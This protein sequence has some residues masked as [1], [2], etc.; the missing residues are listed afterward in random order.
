MKKALALVLVV[1][2]LS[3]GGMC[4]AVSMLSKQQVQV[5]VTPILEQG[6]PAVLEGLEVVLDSRSGD[7]QMHW[8]TTYRP[9]QTPDADTQPY[10]KRFWNDDSMI[11][12][13]Y[14]Y[15]HKDEQKRR[16]ELIYYQEDTGYGHVDP[17]DYTGLDLA[18]QQLEQS[19]ELGTQSARTIAVRD[20]RPFYD[21][22]ARF[23]LP[24]V[25]GYVGAYVRGENWTDLM[26]AQDYQ[27]E[28]LNQFLRIPVQENEKVTITLTKDSQGEVS[29]FGMEQQNED[30]FQFG[31]SSDHSLATDE[32]FY[33]TFNNRTEQ[34][35]VV[36][37]SLI[38][39]GYGIYRIP[40]TVDFDPNKETGILIDQISTVYSIDPSHE[41]LRLHSSHDKSKLLL[42]TLE[43]GWYVLT[44]IDRES[45]T[46]LQR[47]E[48]QE[49]A[50]E[51]DFWKLWEDEEQDIFMV[52]MDKSYAF[53]ALQ[54]DGTYAQIFLCEIPTKVH[55]RSQY[56]D[57][58][59]DGK[60]LVVGDVHN[61]LD[62]TGTAQGVFYLS[63]YDFTGLRYYGEYD[64][65]LNSKIQSSEY[66]SVR[67]DTGTPIKLTWT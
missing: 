14:Q 19:T 26:A 36:D 27:E 37:T 49:K 3:V 7:S 46:A 5:E 17:E 42:H 30:A 45:M 63:V 67:P 41:V 2:T 65:S 9:G 43:N 50:P 12:Y 13:L 58:T 44:V 40:Y 53:F 47:F 10:Y 51:H 33:F 15:D 1:L 34:G 16:M 54:E 66:N 62:T 55:G 6:D 39:G 8:T 56:S 35:A 4:A 24:D 20:Y 57:M 61:W 64:T 52:E 22:S 48:I 59:Y 21:F 32:A 18:F 29:D 11:D 31:V 38:P 28:K 60:R 23:Y 25:E